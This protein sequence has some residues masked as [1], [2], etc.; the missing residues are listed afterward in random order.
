MSTTSWRGQIYRA[1][2]AVDC[3]GQSKYL[4]KQVQGWKPGQAINGLYSFGYKNTVFDRAITF[5]NWL[6]AEYP[7]VKM[8]REVDR[9]MTVEY[10]GEKAENC[11]PDT[12]RTLLTTL[13]KLQEGLWMMNWISEDI[14]P[15]EWIVMGSNPPRGPYASEEAKAIGAWVDGR[16]SEYG[17]ALRFVLSSGARIDEALHLR[18]DKVF[19]D[20]KR[21]ELIGKGG[22]LRKI[23]VLHAEVLRELD[24]SRK[25]VYLDAEQGRLWKDGL[26][27][28]VRKG[29]DALGIRR[30]GVHGFRGT[31]ACEFLD[32]KRALGFTEVE[33]RKELAMWLGH[34]PQRTEITYA[35]VPRR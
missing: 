33:A 11:T 21:V 3:I 13:K 31:A 32:I 28:Y 35:Y 30:R 22:R 19:V 6:R 26:E 25:F 10:L 1:L 34:N 4:A 24:S 20:D 14:V 8:F 5:T 17:Q 12:V 2:N 27:C 23:Q 29:C 15:A 7:Q 16:H 18:S 9:E